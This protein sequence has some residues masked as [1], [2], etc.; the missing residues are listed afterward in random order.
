MWIQSL[1]KELDI[2]QSRPPC[3]LCDNLG[4]T[5]FSTNPI[6]HAQTKHIEVYFHFVRERVAQKAMKIRFISSQDQLAYI[7]TKP[8]H[9]PLITFDTISMLP[10]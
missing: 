3:L 1:L 7:F 4:A 9:S 6:F 2:F 8:P 5:Y 10:L